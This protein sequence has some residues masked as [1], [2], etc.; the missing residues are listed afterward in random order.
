MVA[1]LMCVVHDQ[2]LPQLY[3]VDEHANVD[4]GFGLIC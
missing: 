4:V 1:T 3:V 2:L